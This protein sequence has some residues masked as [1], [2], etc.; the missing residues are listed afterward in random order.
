MGI[1]PWLPTYV[2]E[3]AIPGSLLQIKASALKLQVQ[4]YRKLHQQEVSKLRIRT[5]SISPDETYPQKG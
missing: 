1:S 5:Y 2:C 3:V 4:A